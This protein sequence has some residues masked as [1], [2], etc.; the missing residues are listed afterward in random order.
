MESP[1]LSDY[2]GL[3]KAQSELARKA[4]DHARQQLDQAQRDRCFWDDL[5]GALERGHPA[6]ARLLLRRES[7]LFHRIEAS[8][9]PVAPRL[10]GLRAEL[11]ARAR[12]SA[13]RFAREFPGAAREAGLQIDTTSRHPKY[14][15]KQGFL[16]LE[17]NERD[18][19]AK[20]MPRDG[21]ETIV[22]LDVSLVV[23]TLRTEQTRLFDRP[24][25]A[26]TFLR[27]LYTAYSAIV[28]SEGSKEGDEIPLRRVTNRMAKNLNR[29]A[30]DEF[31]VDLSRLVQTGELLF[32][33]KR[34]H[35]NH[36]RDRRQGMLLQGLESGGYVGFISFKPER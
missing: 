13:G 16:Q 31:N 14:T 23:D 27:S 3:A 29:F 32:D 30:A 7:D 21:A 9:E 4:V 24:I 1:D 8:D 20:V 35:L 5:A 22:G 2:L 19:T 17:V 26:Q 6:H 15:F 18:L 25:E 36:T 11:E 10:R 34:V 33:G 28:R 12:T